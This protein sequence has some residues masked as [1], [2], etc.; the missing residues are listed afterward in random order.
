MFTAFITPFSVRPNLRY[1]LSPGRKVCSSLAYHSTVDSSNLFT[2]DYCLQYILGDS[3]E[4]LGSH[5]LSFS[6]QSQ[7][8]QLG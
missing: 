7:K 5:T 6:V 4:Q 2:W 8:Y 3:S 1:S